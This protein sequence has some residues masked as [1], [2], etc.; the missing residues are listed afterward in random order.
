MDNLVELLGADNRTPDAGI[1]GEGNFWR[2]FGGK[3]IGQAEYALNTAF[4]DRSYVIRPGCLPNKW[5]DLGPALLYDANLVHKHTW[6]SGDEPGFLERNANRALLS[7]RDSPDQ[8]FYLFGF[9]GHP[10]GDQRR[11]DVKPFRPYGAQ[12]QLPTMVVGD[13]FGHPSGPKFEPDTYAEHFDELCHY[14]PRMLF[15]DGIPVPG[16]HPFDT[17]A[18]DYLC[19]RWRRGRRDWR[20]AWLTR[21]PGGRVGGVGFSHMA[22]LADD[23]TPTN[24]PAP[25]GRPPTQI[26]AAVFNPRA[27]AMLVPGSVLI[28]EP[29][30]QINSHKRISF[31]MAFPTGTEGPE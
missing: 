10:D 27:A 26:D 7:P 19:G 6:D 24:F 28:H 8:K 16:D 14:A 17:H 2:L 9:H 11:H 18:L 12:A 4:R 13:F 3:G 30:Q 22:E 23:Y 29:A 15:P 31:R 5:G 20:R 21:K 25:N 1:I